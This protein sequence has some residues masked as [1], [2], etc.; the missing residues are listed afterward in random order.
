[1]TSCTKCVRP[2]TV[3]NPIHGS[4]STT[5]VELVDT[6]GLDASDLRPDTDILR[7]IAEW[8]QKEWVE[9]RNASLSSYI[10]QGSLVCACSPDTRVAGI[11]CMQNIQNLKLRNEMGGIGIR[12]ILALPGVS[13]VTTHWSSRSKTEGELKEQQLIDSLERQDSKNILC[14]RFDY[15]NGKDSAWSIIRDV[16]ESPPNET[17]GTLAERLRNLSGKAPPKKKKFKF[18]N[19]L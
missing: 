16:V 13:L 10:S 11:L 18:R 3:E 15:D 1:V 4:G 8:L 7:E 14:L 5:H 12:R 6:P 19:L 17:R 9:F 2:F